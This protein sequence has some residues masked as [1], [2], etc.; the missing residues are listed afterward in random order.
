MGSLGADSSEAPGESVPAS[1][2]PFALAL[3]PAALISQSQ[4]TWGI[5][6]YS[7]V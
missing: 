2:M 1:P 6:R 5:A 3:T 4:I 7:D